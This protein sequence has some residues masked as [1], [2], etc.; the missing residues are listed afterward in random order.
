MATV[1]VNTDVAS[2]GG[3][4]SIGNPY[5]TLAEALTPFRLAGSASSQLTIMCS[6]TS[7]DPGV[8]GLA[9]AYSTDHTVWEFTTTATNYI[10]IIGD[11]TSGKWDTSKYRIEVTNRAAIYNQ[12][13]GHVRFT[14]VQAQVK[15]TNAGNYVVFRLSTAN[16]GNGTDPVN[17]FFQW[18][19]CIARKDPTSTAGDRVDGWDNSICGTGTQ[20]GPLY[21][22]N[23]IFIGSETGSSSSG[24]VDDGGTWI[25][26]N[27][28]IYNCTAAKVNFGFQIVGVA[29]NCLATACAF[30]FVAAGAGTDYCATDDGNGIPGGG[31]HNSNG[32][33][34]ATF[35]F[36]DA[37]NGDYHLSSSDTGAKD[38]G[39]INPS[40]GVYFDDI[41][42]E[43]RTAAWDIGFDEITRTAG[44][45]QFA[46]S[47]GGTIATSAS[48]WSLA[49]PANLSGGSAFIIGIGVASSAV[50]VSTITD[51]TTN[52]Y[53][54]AVARGTPR[55]VAGAEL[56]YCNQCSSASTRISITLSATSSGS[57]GF[58]EFVGISTGTP[59]D[60]TAS[61]AITANST[62]HSAAQITPSTLKNLAVSFCRL[63]QSTIGTV[64]TLGGM[65]RWISTNVAAR[66]VGQYII[67]AAASSVTGSFTTSS[68]CQHA[69]VLAVF[70][71]T[72]AIAGGTG[73]HRYWGLTFTGVQS[74]HV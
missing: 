71:D 34:A 2:A 57:I 68:G 50:T 45:L 39:L 13:T 24:F 15:S 49:C 11:N 28:K 70:N 65:T 29:K 63:D 36:V 55:P 8:S 64:T 19:G 59:L 56:W 38:L 42:G 72:N 40:S 66:T 37:A 67:Q 43:T 22:I 5:K 32:G 25:T 73:R 69:A 61:S 6:G 74:A 12:Y 7:A 41:D 1:Y 26:N 52:V 31:T 16:N 3:D 9:S 10:E 27:M 51:N 48:T 53:L 44:S 46:Q 18:K 60:Q 21:I 30:G 20:N 54:K 17:P 14:N 62:S 23:S 58:L 35:T 4:G 33:N 47:K